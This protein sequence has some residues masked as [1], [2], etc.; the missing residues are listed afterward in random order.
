M[1]KFREISE[2]GDNIFSFRMNNSIQS[3]AR[4]ISCHCSCWRFPKGNILAGRDVSESI[5]G[6]VCSRGMRYYAL[7]EI[8]PATH[9]HSLFAKVDVSDFVYP[10]RV[11]NRFQI[12]LPE[13]AWMMDILPPTLVIVH[14]FES[15]WTW[16]A[17]LLNRRTRTLLWTGRFRK[18]VD[19]SA[20][21]LNRR[22]RISL[23]CCFS[24]H[25]YMRT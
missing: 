12:L 25:A 5:G 7:A 14:V 9:A 1:W 10:F 11:W 21:L 22:T 19:R 23:D 17:T 16:S 6:R 15:L 13:T 18:L 8:E 3:L 2:S 20:T 24:L 4:T